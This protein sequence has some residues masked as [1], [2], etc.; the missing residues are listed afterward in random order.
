MRGSGRNSQLD[1]IAFD[2]A[3]TQPSDQALFASMRKAADISAR[4]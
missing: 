4:A 2:P 3:L 1:S